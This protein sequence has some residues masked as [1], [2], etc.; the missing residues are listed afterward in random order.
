MHYY[1][2]VRI[3]QQCCVKKI[4]YD[5]RLNSYHV[6]VFV[7]EANSQANYWYKTIVLDFER[8]LKFKILNLRS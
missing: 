6:P 7:E 4:V 3:I 8:N 5:K 2:F 1:V